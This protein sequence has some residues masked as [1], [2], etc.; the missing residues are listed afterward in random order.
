MIAKHEVFDLMD[1]LLEWSRD[2]D[3]FDAQTSSDYIGCKIPFPMEYLDEDGKY[4][5]IR[6]FCIERLLAKF[7]AILNDPAKRSTS[8]NYCRA[9]CVITSPNLFGSEVGFAFSEEKW[10]SMLFRDVDTGSFFEQTKINDG[11]LEKTYAVQVP[12]DCNSIKLKHILRD[13]SEGISYEGTIYAIWK[14]IRA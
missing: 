8:Q 14:D 1:R 4:N 5:G 2:S 6:Q 12:A 13:V 9:Y 3:G 10:K 7:V 11:S